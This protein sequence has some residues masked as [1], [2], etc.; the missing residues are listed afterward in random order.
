MRWGRMYAWYVVQRTSL[1]KNQD[2]LWRKPIPLAT[3]LWT[4]SR[5]WLQERVLLIT[6]PRYLQVLNLFYDGTIELDP[7]QWQESLMTWMD[8]HLSFSHS[9]ADHLQEAI[10]R[11][12]IFGLQQ[13]AIFW[14]HL[15][16]G[17]KLSV[18]LHLVNSKDKGLDKKSLGT[19]KSL[20]IF[21]YSVFWDNLNSL[22]WLGH[23]PIISCRM[24]C[25]T[26]V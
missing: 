7:K 22:R 17:A 25:I 21:R 8:K 5:C 24:S 3:L 14:T 12:R 11:Q 18:Q 6:T 4:R 23:W 1:G 15:Y 19:Y 13:N 20:K 16:F 26:A 10:S 2:S 9:A